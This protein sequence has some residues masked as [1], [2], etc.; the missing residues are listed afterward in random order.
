[1][2]TGLRYLCGKHPLTRTLRAEVAAVLEQR[3]DLEVVKL[4]DGRGTTGSLWVSDAGG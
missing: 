3:P 2:I 1:M 4:A